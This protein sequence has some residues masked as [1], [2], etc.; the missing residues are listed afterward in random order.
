MMKKYITPLGFITAALLAGAC[1]SDDTISIKDDSEKTAIEFSMTDNTTK[2]VSISGQTRAGFAAATKIVM[3]M[4]AQNGTSTSD[5]KYT[6]T[7]ATA[8]TEGND[9]K[10]SAVNFSSDNGA[11]TRY[12]DDAYGRNTCLSVYAVAVPSKTTLTTIDALAG[13]TTNTWDQTSSAN[14]I[15]WSVSTDQSTTTG[16]N[17]KTPIDDE[18]LV[19][20]NNIQAN[21]AEMKLE[22]GVCNWDFTNGGYKTYTGDSKT[23]LVAGQMKFTLKNSSESS[24]PGKFDKGNLNFTH[25][26]SRITINVK[27]GDGF[28]TSD[29]VTAAKLLKM[30][31]TGTLDVQAGTFL[32]T[33]TETITMDKR[34]ALEDYQ[35]QYLGQV[36]PD[37]EISKNSDA[38]VL[39]FNVGDNVYYVTQ[40]SVYNALVTD[41]NKSKLTTL[42]ENNN[43]FTMA[44]G[45]NYVL[46]I[47]VSKTKIENITATLAD[48]TDITG[49]YARNN[50]Y[51]TFSFLNTGTA[52]TTA[53][54]FDIYRAADDYD[55]YV[56]EDSYVTKNPHYNWTTG[57]SSEGASLTYSDNLWKTSWYWDTN[58]AFYHF[59]LVGKQKTSESETAATTVT[60]DT[61]GDYFAIKAGATS[62]NA[63]WGAPFV[64]G[65][66]ISYN[67]TNGFAVNAYSNTEGSKTSP[68]IS[69]AIGA[70]N[71]NINFTMLNMLAHIKVNILTTSGND[72]VKLIDGNTATKVYLSKIYTAGTVN[73]GNGLVKQ[74][75]SRTTSNTEMTA[76]TGEDLKVGSNRIKGSYDYYVVPQSLIDGQ[77]YVGLYIETPDKNV[78]YVVQKLSEIT[79]TSVTN[80]TSINIGQAKD[81]KILYWYP[82][83][84]YTYN[85]TLT[86]TGITKITAT[87]VPYTEISG[88]TNISIED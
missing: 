63:T 25:A 43:K 37:Y 6:K 50:A 42:D 39:Q 46:N 4:V 14:T 52:I 82:N 13:P 31:Y 5:Y 11:T 28:T 19:Y 22:N 24:G 69:P 65:S 56:T 35:A 16:D 41:A 87:L 27:L 23:N 62:Q 80:G 70:T 74:T 59:R 53:N 72:A 67:T 58:K 84:C 2:T 9:T 18:D 8:E 51:L 55:Q 7:S 79:A 47:T 10:L 17:A 64:S 83:C 81:A 40:A 68:I 60:T 61:N 45:Q 71:S 20:S 48:W 85:I 38:N 12:W 15:S 73:M 26:L 75:G 1:S 54:S 34:T 3:R 36:L 76:P 49:A 29:Q 21:S 33:S 77:T 86:K 32:S 88:D 57:Y 66:T 30:P 44:Q 78:Y